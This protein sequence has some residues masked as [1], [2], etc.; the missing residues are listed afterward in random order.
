MKMEAINEGICL[1]LESMCCRFSS[2]RWFLAAIL[3]VLE[4][5]AKGLVFCE[6]LRKKAQ[7]FS[8]GLLSCV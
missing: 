2:Y 8:A 4:L 1:I 7:L 3:A 6:F 5:F